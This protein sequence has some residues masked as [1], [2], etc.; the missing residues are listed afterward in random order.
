MCAATSRADDRIPLKIAAIDWCPQICPGKTDPGYII[1]IVEELFRS[2]PYEPEI[3]IYPWS[4]AIQYVRS[5]RAHALLSP[6]KPEAPDLVYPEEEVGVQSM[7]FF[8]LKDS[9]WNYDGVKS[10]EGHLTGLASDT[11]IQELNAFI[12]E[13][14]D[15]FFVQPYSDA[16]I[17]DSINMLYAN[18]VNSFLFTYN[19][20]LHNMRSMG[21]SDEV[22]SAGCVS[23]ASVYMAFSP[24]PGLAAE[25]QEMTAYFD[26][27]MAQFKADGG[28]ARIMK[29]YELSDWSVAEDPAEHHTD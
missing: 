22:R 26:R 6:A 21:V 12:Q 28:V 2:S 19:T 9:T 24:A 18:R 14:R 29:H 15:L 1:D 13:R 10:L 8:V 25:V 3:S 11:S 17:Q 4:R 23:N 16:Y 5:G 20:T 7:C 27:K